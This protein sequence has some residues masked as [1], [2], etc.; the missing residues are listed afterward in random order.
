MT[1]TQ[2]AKL[3][4]GTLVT[5]SRYPGTVYKIAS[6]YETHQGPQALILYS[7][8]TKGINPLHKDL[9]TDRLIAA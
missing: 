8:G 9:S 5:V 7:G 4:I 1:A 2:T 3:E 6:L